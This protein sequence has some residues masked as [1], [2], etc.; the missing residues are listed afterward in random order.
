[1]QKKSW[2]RL[3]G[4]IVIE[5]ACAVSALAAGYEYNAGYAELGQVKAVALEDKRGQRA[6]IVT[7][8]FSVPLSVADSIAAEAIKQYHLERSSILIYS[9]ASGDP[10][11]QQALTTLGAALGKLAPAIL[12]YGDRRLTVSSGTGQCLVAVSP[13]TSLEPC[14]TPAGDLV[15]SPIRSALQMVDLDRGLTTRESAPRSVVIQ[16]ISLGRSVVIFSAPEDFSQP[17]KHTIL[18][19]TPAL[20]GDD[21]NVSK[22]VGEVF[23]RIGG[24]PKN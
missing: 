18:A 14:T 9:V 22:A 24:R 13:Q 2:K 5:L 19:M 1:M 21:T 3:A 6:A 10:N 16:A 11:P 12:I 8:A 4:F 15:H 23:I 17:G 7:A 20:G